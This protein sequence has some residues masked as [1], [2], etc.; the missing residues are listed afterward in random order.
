MM[1]VQRVGELTL[2]EL[3]Q[4]IREEITALDPLQTG[5]DIDMEAAREAVEWFKH[6]RL[7]RNPDSPSTLDL[8]RADRDR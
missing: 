6:N 1:A 5:T 2:A 4:I 3:R 8:L 7:P